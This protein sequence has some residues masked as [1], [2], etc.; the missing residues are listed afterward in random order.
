MS[1]ETPA[2]ARPD[3]FKNL[4]IILMTLISIAAAALTFL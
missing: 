3:L 1:V 2:R 4:V